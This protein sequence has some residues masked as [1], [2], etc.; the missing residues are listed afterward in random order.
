MAQH[1]FK[2]VANS[3]LAAGASDVEALATAWAGLYNAG[4]E[5]TEKGEYAQ[6][7]KQRV[8]FAKRAAGDT[9][10]IRQVSITAPITHFEK[11]DDGSLKVFGW[12]SVVIDKDGNVVV[13]HDEDIIEASEIE[14]ASYNFVK[15]SGTANGMHEGPD[16]G[17][18]IECVAFTP[19]KRVAMGL[20]GSGPTGMWVG[21]DVFD[22]GAI[23][24]VRSGEWT[25]FSIE[26]EAHRHIEPGI[27][28]QRAKLRDLVINK[29][30]LV[31]SGAGRGVTV[32]LVKGI[33]MNLK[34]LM[35]KIR[36]ALALKKK[37]GEGQDPG[38]MLDA[39]L[40]KLSPEE[41]TI[42]EMAMQAAA[43]SGMPPPTEPTPVDE[44][45]PEDMPEEQRKSIQK[46]R[47]DAADARAEV[48]KLR[49][50]KDREGFV[51]FAKNKLPM[52]SGMSSEEMGEVLHVAKGRL[53]E[54][55]YDKLTNTLV[56]TNKALEESK[57]FGEEGSSGEPAPD[58]GE[59]EIRALAQ[60]MMKEDPNLNEA[61]AYQKAMKY[62][63][64]RQAMKKHLR[65]DA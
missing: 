52:I 36:K 2:R 28:K 11:R 7:V 49:N 55:L 27:A 12:G 19:E 58:S 39:I 45:L 16:V 54:A 21:F 42:V 1:L 38:A 56:S 10:D 47:Q 29:I 18:L 46:A 20:D 33:K 6:V 48:Q 40:G 43:G 63:E 53:S 22:K 4:W 50:E 32:Q 57:V 8:K 17:S 3:A 23:Q 5:K 25:E 26:G 15:T 9:S 64:G 59:G 34:Q 35:E 44:P 51:K 37:E 65:P 14:K 31:D 41:R 13:D 30:A 62:P 24:K 60:K 61:K